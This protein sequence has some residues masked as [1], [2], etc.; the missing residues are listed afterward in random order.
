M[1]RTVRA[2]SRTSKASTRHFFVGT[3]HRETRGGRYWEAIV[4]EGKSRERAAGSSQEVW[5]VVQADSVE[6][7]LERASVTTRYLNARRMEQDSRA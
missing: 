1:V 3:P 6:E 7:V 4:F 2:V 5:A